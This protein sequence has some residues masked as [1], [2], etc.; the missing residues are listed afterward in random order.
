MENKLEQLCK[1]DPIEECPI[2]LDNLVDE[3]LITECNHKFH[4]NCFVNHYWKCMDNNLTL[5]CPICRINL[6]DDSGWFLSC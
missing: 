2:C 4:I 5:N 1:K 3:I 6:K